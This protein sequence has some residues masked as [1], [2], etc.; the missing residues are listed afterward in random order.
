M[1][2]AGVKV[3]DKFAC[4]LRVEITVNDVSFLL[5]H[6]RR[7]GHKGATTTRELA[8]LKK[9]IYNSIQEVREPKNVVRRRGRDAI[10]GAAP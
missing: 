7:V 3:Y 4:L 2:A 9:S 8:P 5:K 10:Q 1:G 6:H